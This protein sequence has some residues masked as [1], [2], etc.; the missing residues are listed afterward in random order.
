MPRR[1]RIEMPGGVYHVT[2]RGV[3][4]TNI[5][6]DDTDREQWYRLF[7][8]AAIRCHW[9]VFA[10]V[11]MTNHFH[12]FLK[13]P[14]P[15]LSEGMHAIESGYATYFNKRHERHGALFQ[16]RFHAVLVEQESHA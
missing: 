6:R 7:T 3:D 1:L 11:L 16:G 8:R 12:I 14:E 10:E 2:N 4:R 13:T 15:N 5:V 9:R